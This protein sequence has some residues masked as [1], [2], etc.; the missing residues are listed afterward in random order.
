MIFVVQTCPPRDPAPLVARLEAQGAE[1]LE[2][3]DVGLEGELRGMLRALALAADAGGGPVTLL[4]DDVRICEGFAPY[5]CEFWREPRTPV[6]RWYASG[7]L[8]RDLPAGW[9]V[10]PGALYLC[11]QATTLSR[12][13][14]L[15]LI[16]SPEAL[17]RLKANDR[18]SGDAL[19]GEHLANLGASFATHLPGLVQHEGASSIVVP[20]TNAQRSRL[21]Q[22]IYHRSVYFIGDGVDART[23]RP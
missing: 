8:T 7:D 15:S 9:N 21:E 6:V 4:E 17:R 18:H 23:V 13:F 14:V 20:N 5:V 16:R 3:P 22:G 12:D 11:N 10:Q 19:I 1:V 2:V